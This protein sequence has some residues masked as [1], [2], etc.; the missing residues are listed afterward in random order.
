MSN[1]QPLVSVGLPVYNGQNFVAEA[2]QA[3]LSQTFSDWELIIS[4]NA[5]TDRTVSICRGF[6]D[7][8]GRI[9]LYESKRNMGVAPNFNRVFQLS[10]GQ[11]F[12]WLA[13]DDLVGAAFLESCIQELEN[14]EHAALAFPKLAYVDANGRP[15]HR[16][17]SDIFIL[18]STAEVRVIQLMKLATR[19]THIFWSQFGLIRRSVLEQTRLMDMYNG[20]DQVLLLKIAVLGN[21]KQVDKELFFRREHPAAATLRRGWT[22]KEMATFVSADDKRTL[23]FPN[24][25][26][27]KEH[28]VCLWGTSISFWGKIRC[29]AA[30]MKRFW[31]KW[32]DFV[33]ELIDSPSQVLRAKLWPVLNPVSSTTKTN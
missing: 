5:S 16:Q 30:I 11:Y 31:P 2:I 17:I 10:R 14:D 29:A 18:G 24:C 15:L 33:R 1:K 6:A 25:R 3:I 26:L 28:F 13:H 7:K 22:A 21:F 27:L 20:S 8:D 9:R 32:K 12:M 19:S 23:V 4:D